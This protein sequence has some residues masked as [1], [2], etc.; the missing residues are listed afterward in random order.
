[1]MWGKIFKN[2]PSKIC[3]RRPLKNLKWYMVCLNRQYHFSFFKDCLPQILLSSFLNTL[4]H[5][6]SKIFCSVYCLNVNYKNIFENLRRCLFEVDTQ[7]CLV[8]I[9]VYS[10]IQAFL[11]FNHNRNLSFLNAEWLGLVVLH[12]VYYV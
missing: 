8:I 6:S 7:C 1:M 10:I 12:Y 2:G 4:S 3:G 9:R 5:M 11:V